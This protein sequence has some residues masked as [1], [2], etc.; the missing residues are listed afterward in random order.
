[1]TIVVK[2]TCG[3]CKSEW[4]ERMEVSR[5]EL[6]RGFSFSQVCPSCHVP[7]TFYGSSESLVS[8]M[9]TTTMTVYRMTGWVDPASNKK[10]NHEPPN[11]NPPNANM[12]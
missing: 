8:A 2:L 9:T 5:M 12:A 7:N 6:W 3:K 4:E 10:T 1:M 11:F